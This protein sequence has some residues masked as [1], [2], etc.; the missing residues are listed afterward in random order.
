[1][2]CALF[3]KA[4]QRTYEEVIIVQVRVWKFIY[5]FFFFNKLDAW[6]ENIDIFKS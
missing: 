6:C 5:S 1:M 4:N 3:L 2:N